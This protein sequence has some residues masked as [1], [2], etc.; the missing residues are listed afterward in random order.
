MD[1]GFSK[2]HN[3]ECCCNTAA[4]Y[5]H[6]TTWPEVPYSTLVWAQDCGV[7]AEFEAIYTLCVLMV[8]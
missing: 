8:S 7:C 6:I 3:K 4:P 2:G 5:E 1:M